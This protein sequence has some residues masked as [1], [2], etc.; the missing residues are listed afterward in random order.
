MAFGASFRRE[1][2]RIE[3]SPAFDEAVVD[4]AELAFRSQ[5]LVPV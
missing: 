1:E 3:G 5:A 2:T 4:G